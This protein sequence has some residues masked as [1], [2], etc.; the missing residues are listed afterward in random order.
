MGQ[1]AEGPRL[2]ATAVTGHCPERQ[3]AGRL[4]A[5]HPASGHPFPGCRSFTKA[6][7]QRQRPPSTHAPVRQSRWHGPAPSL[8]SSPAPAAATRMTGVPPPP[9][10]LSMSL[11]AVRPVAHR[12]RRPHGPRRLRIRPP[13]SVGPLPL[14]AVSHPQ[15]STQPSDSAATVSRSAPRNTSRARIAVTRQRV[16]QPRA[17][18]HPRGAAASH[19]RP[20]AA[21]RP[22]R[23]SRCHRHRRYS[24]PRRSSRACPTAAPASCRRRLCP[25]EPL[26]SPASNHAAATGES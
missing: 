26:L 9:P 17:L 10:P 20:G 3:R 25:F 11:P 22:R 14:R 24:P 6:A 5:S 16:R 13:P 7:G 15:S 18:L 19:R 12:S 21:D 4:D 1:L 8:H 23:P 2:S